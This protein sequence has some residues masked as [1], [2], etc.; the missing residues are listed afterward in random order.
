M[1]EPLP[2]EPASMDGPGDD[3]D[4]HLFVEEEGV[5]VSSEDLFELPTTAQ[6]L[7]G[8]DPVESAA[9]MVASTQADAEPEIAAQPAPSS[10]WRTRAVLGAL[11][12]INVA[13]IGAVLTRNHTPGEEIAE[14]PPPAELPIPSIAA[15]TPAPAPAAR[16]PAPE[17]A[18]PQVQRTGRERLEA[19]E[20]ALAAGR[21]D[22][23]RIEIGRLLL[24]TDA[25][26]GNERE[27]TRAQAE[28]RVARILQDEA[29]EA[30]R[31]PR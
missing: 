31:L 10:R 28:L 17:A 8:L 3:D 20:V 25:L 24:V 26:A 18:M 27:E 6:S 29:D 14:S 21:R 12:L 15:P 7:P 23:A 5:V 22:F 1:T 2:Q 11:G 4:Y 30:R 16:V 9:A 19:I 13:V